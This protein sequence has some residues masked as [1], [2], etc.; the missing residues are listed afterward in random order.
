M[1]CPRKSTE[2]YPLPQL[3]RTIDHQLIIFLQ[4]YNLWSDM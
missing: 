3:R 4:K 2:K 1:Q